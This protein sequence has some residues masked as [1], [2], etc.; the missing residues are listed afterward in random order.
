MQNK[1]GNERFRREV[2]EV[3]GRRVAP[4]KHGRRKG[5]DGI[6]GEQ[7]ALDFEQR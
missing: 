2:E 7:I 4:K 5:V 3:L 6:E 1:W